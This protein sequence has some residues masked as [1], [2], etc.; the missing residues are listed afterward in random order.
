MSVVKDPTRSMTSY[1]THCDK[2]AK[3][4]D[5][6]LADNPDLN[7]KG[8]QVL[9]KL[10]ADLEEQ[11]KRMEVSWFSMMNNIEDV[12]IH[13][14]MEKVFNDVDDHVTKTLRTS[15]SMGSPHITT[16]TRKFWI[17]WHR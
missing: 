2:N 17:N 15:G 8:I 14:A 10:N 6:F 9:E 4:I 11:F 7:P 13:T 16:I 1:K 3:K 12:P 5:D